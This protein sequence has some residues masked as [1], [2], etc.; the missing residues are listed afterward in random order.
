MMIKSKNLLVLMLTLFVS[1]VVNA[2][3]AYKQLEA[4]GIA[5]VG[6]N[7][8]KKDGKYLVNGKIVIVRN[9]KNYNLNGQAE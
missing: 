2:E 7:D 4:T 6:M 1:V 9:G 3:N 8:G 5:D